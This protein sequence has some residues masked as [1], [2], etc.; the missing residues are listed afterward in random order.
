MWER[1][2][3][4]GEMEGSKR[5]THSHMWDGRGDP[6]TPYIYMLPHR[7][8]GTGYRSDTGLGLSWMKYVYESKWAVLRISGSM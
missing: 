2:E 4:S 7:V 1:K 5:C 3:E 8:N 6:Q